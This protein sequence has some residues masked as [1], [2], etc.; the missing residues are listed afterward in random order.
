MVPPFVPEPL[1]EL[2]E[3]P[4]WGRGSMLEGEVVRCV[5]GGEL[6]ANCQGIGGRASFVSS[7][8][9][10]DASWEAMGGIAG[11]DVDVDTG[12]DDDAIAPGLLSV[13]MMRSYTRGGR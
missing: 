2:P 10:T 3:F 6:I 13:P 5:E 4:P 9:D 12:G 11:D 7:F 1:D 8:T